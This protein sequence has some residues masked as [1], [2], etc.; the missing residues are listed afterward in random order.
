MPA[1]TWNEMTPEEQAEINAQEDSRESYKEALSA[2]DEPSDEDLAEYFLR[3][4]EAQDG[5][6]DRFYW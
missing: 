6:R 1:K 3:M 2:S 5:H 4:E